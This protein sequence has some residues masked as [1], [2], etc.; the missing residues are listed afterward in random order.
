VIYSNTLT[1]GGL[2][3]TLAPIGVPV[4]THAHELEYWIT[5]LGPE[6]LRLTLQHTRH[7]IA[8]AEAVAMNLRIRHGVDPSRLTVIHEHIARLPAPRDAA[9]RERERRRLGLAPGTFVI[10][11]CGAEYWR[12]GRDLIPGLIRA[13]QR[14]LP[15]RPVSFLWIGRSGTPEEEHGLHHD[16]RLTGTAPAYLATGELADPFPSY[17][18][19]DAFALLSR[20]DPF[21]LACLEATAAG[22]PVVC[23]A[24]AGGMPE[25][26]ARGTG[27]SVPYLDLEAMAEQLAQL[28]RHPA[29]AQALAAK[30]REEVATRH[31]P[32]HTGP[33]I[34]D[35]LACATKAR[36]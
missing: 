28:A 1:N 10:G 23:F 18:A 30:G 17:A 6:N 13:V 22:A 9:T 21:P 31:L 33:R 4:V 5:R 19:L 11:S 24:E 7:F 29:Q 35:V 14:R 15:G 20:D 16:L 8:A 12:K 34:L 32:E 3:A 26:T 2:L 36:S 27:I 25:F